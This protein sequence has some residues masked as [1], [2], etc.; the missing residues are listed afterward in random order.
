MGFLAGNYSSAQGAAQSGLGWGQASAGLSAVGSVLQ[1]IGG[2][3]QYGFA[4]SIA[5]LNAKIAQQ[6]A[7]AALNAGAYAESAS[8]L[9][10]GELI[11]AQRA[12]QAANGVDVN[13][14][15]PVRTRESAA[16]V[17][18][19]D[20]AMIHYNAMRE[21]YGD[22]VTA[23][24]EKAQAGA[25]RAAGLGAL[26]GGLFNAGSGLLS[27]GSSLSSK[28]AQYQ[29]GAPGNGRGMTVPSAG[30]NEELPY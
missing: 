16:T 30:G 27:S 4:A 17:G 11:S 8:K 22:L 14:G 1:G 6:N 28:W 21:A 18:A 25:Y 26:A 13:V 23:S 19:M 12:A 9:R 5:D 7:G 20:A 15:T 24:A 3:Q 10:T 2:Q 29:L